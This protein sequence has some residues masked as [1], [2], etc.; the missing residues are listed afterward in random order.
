MHIKLTPIMML[1]LAFPLAAEE[2][3]A[4]STDR[5]FGLD[6]INTVHLAGSDEAALDFQ[7]NEQPNLMNIVDQTLNE[8]ALV[9]ASHYPLDPT[10]LDLVTD[11]DVRV[12][13]LGEG[14]GYHNTLGISFDGTSLNG[15]DDYLIFPDA[16]SSASWYN[17]NSYG[18]RS[19]NYPSLQATTS[20]LACNRPALPWI[21]S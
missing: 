20:T 14:A 17:G 12:Y 3:P 7:Q 1:L 9:D 13:F 18:S 11:S 2:S 6:I 4:Q 21:F 8:R 10:K 5:P 19:E 16:S 15:T